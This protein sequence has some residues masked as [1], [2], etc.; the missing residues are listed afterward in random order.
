MLSPF[1]AEERQV[2]NQVIPRV[3]EAILSILT[4]GLTTAMNKF[5]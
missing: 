2:I 4:D 1:T 5:N 3:S